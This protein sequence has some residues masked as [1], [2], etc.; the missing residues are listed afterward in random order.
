MWSL[1]RKR[2]KLFTLCFSISRL[3][4][5]LKLEEQI[6]GAAVSIILNNADALVRTNSILMILLFLQPYHRWGLKCRPQ[7]CITEGVIVFQ[8]K[9]Y[10]TLGVWTFC[11]NYPLRTINVQRKFQGNL[12][13]NCET[14]KRGVIA[15]QRALA[16]SKWKWKIE[17]VNSVLDT[18]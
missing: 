8:N 4:A 1:C 7:G 6:E 9:H 16:G 3:L 15:V 5:S 12:G 13:S 10:F 17:Y 11:V 14:E 18:V 2:R